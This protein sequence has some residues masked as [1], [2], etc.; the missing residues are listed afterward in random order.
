MIS[1]RW[2]VFALGLIIRLILMPYTTHT[3]TWEIGIVP[4]DTLYNLGIN[5]SLFAPELGGTYYVFYTPLYLF[6]AIFNY[7]GIYYQFLLEFLMKIPPTIGDIITFYSLYEITL[8]LS[9]NQRTSL[10]VAT[11]YFLNPFIIMMSAV[12]GHDEQLIAAFMLLSFLLLLK[13]KIGYSAICLSLAVSREYLPI[14]V[15]P[16]FLAYVWRL[17]KPFSS[18]MSFLAIFS[19]SSFAL[20]I[21]EGLTLAQLY[22]ASPKV[23]WDYVLFKVQGPM[24]LVISIPTGFKHNFTGFLAALGIW[25]NVSVFFR[26]QTIILLYIF[27]TIILLRKQNISS[28]QLITRHVIT[29]FLLFLIVNPLFQPHYLLWF[30]PF[31]FLETSV[32]LGLPRYFP[33]VL[34]GS[35]LV[36]EPLIE[37]SFRYWSYIV[38]TQ[39]IFSFWQIDNWLLKYAISVVTGLFLILGIL[40]L[41]IDQAHKVKISSSSSENKMHACNK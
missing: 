17:K 29:S 33:H 2:F 31:L 11:M 14:I 41:T 39:R 18:K 27:V 1:K 24:G 34:W 32:F 7:F 23:L 20:F 10:S 4:M 16:S 13:G 21:P 3:A 25:P 35:I 6:Y 15:L 22:L 37:G 9:R 40:F 30:L 12:Y 5:P 19:A 26:Y 28:A 36:V 38:P 8:H